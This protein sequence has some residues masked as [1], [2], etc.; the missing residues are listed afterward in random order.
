MDRTFLFLTKSA[1]KMEEFK[2]LARLQEEEAILHLF[3]KTKYNLA[4]DVCSKLTQNIKQERE[5][6]VFQIGKEQTTIPA[7]LV[8]MFTNIKSNQI[9]LSDKYHIQEVMNLFEIL[10]N[11]PNYKCEGVLRDYSDWKPIASFV[12]MT[13]LATKFG[14][15]EVGVYLKQ[16][17]DLFTEHNKNT[18]R[19][20]IQ[21]R[22]KQKL[23]KSIV[24]KRPTDDLSNPNVKQENRQTRSRRRSRSLTDRLRK[25]LSGTRKDKKN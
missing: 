21:R 7:S 23:E 2:D 19:N 25:S 12:N 13:E 3:T 18:L 20:E 14:M 9:I 10:I 15:Q 24:D 6:V 16:L 5:K 11:L 8:R 4:I 17:A 22:E 1:S